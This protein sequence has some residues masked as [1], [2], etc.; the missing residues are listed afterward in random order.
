MG[1]QGSEAL[2]L[3]A[4]LALCEAA[5]EGVRYEAVGGKA[6]MMSSP[7]GPHQLALVE[8]VL[9]L[10]MAVP[11]D[12]VVLVSPLDWVLW[13]VPSLTVRQPDLVVT[14]FDQSGQDRLT[15]PPVLVVEVLSP[16]TRVTDLRDKRVE[17]ARAGAAHYWVVDL[18]GPSVE[19]LALDPATGTYRSAGSAEGDAVLTVTDPF[20]VSVAPAD[21]VRKGGGPWAPRATRH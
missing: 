5:P 6:V 14:T 13:E 21:L 8:L 19:A 18:Q 4:F 17:Y 3:E 1:S 7:T 12:L 9:R 11:D 10:R 2:T 15:L 20:P 16:T